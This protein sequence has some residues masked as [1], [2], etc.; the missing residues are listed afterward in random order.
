MLR[1]G[2]LVSTGPVAELNRL[3]L[4]SRMLGRDA[5]DL[6]TGRTQ[7]GGG[8]EIADEAPVLEANGPAAQV[9]P[10]GHLAGRAPG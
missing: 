2:K 10:R 4:I 3:Q 7:F 8:G 1:D 6:E 5:S 9:R